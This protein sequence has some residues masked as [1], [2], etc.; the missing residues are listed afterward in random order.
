M[1]LALLSSTP[2][3]FPTQWLLRLETAKIESIKK[4]NAATT[5]YKA[6][7]KVSH[8]RINV[9]P[10]EEWFCQ[11][12]EGVIEECS[13]T[14][15]GQDAISVRG[16]VRGGCIESVLVWKERLSHMLVSLV[17]NFFAHAVD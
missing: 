15:T 7:S 3:G 11:V 4:M 1:E 17:Y 6:V 12:Y 16:Y 5:V 10:M 13:N 14:M 9:K 8:Q 2:S